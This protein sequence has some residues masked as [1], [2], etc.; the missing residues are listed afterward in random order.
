MRFLRSRPSLRGAM[1][2]RA[3]HGDAEIAPVDG[4]G[5]RVAQDV[6]A[7]VAAAA[8][9]L[10]ARYGPRGPGRLEKQDSTREGRRSAGALLRLLVFVP[11]WTVNL[12]TGF[13]WATAKSTP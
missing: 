6:A 5:R 1:R 13:P 11:S 10:E 7:R 9:G 3:R 2:A 12:Q 4:D 8:D